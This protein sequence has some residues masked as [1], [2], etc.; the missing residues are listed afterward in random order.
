MARD[1]DQS[2][3]PAESTAA[4]WYCLRAQP[5]H[6]RI[7]AVHL[8]K[9]AGIDVFAPMMRYQ[10]PRKPGGKVWVSEAMFPGYL[11]AHFEFGPRFREVRSVHGVRGIVQFGGRSPEVSNAFLDELK[12]VLGGDE[13]AVVTE[14]PEPGTEVLITGG[15]FR[16]LRALVSQYFPAKERVRVLLE[17]LGRGVEV[18]LPASAVSTGKP[19]HPLA[20]PAAET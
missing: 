14:T 7:A 13:T 12:A 17:M 16:D 9:C 19:V 8:R 2:N 11:F 20:E 4:A 5:K 6:E 15:V 10:R 1:P 3:R 18:E